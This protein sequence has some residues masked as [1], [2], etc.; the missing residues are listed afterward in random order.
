MVAPKVEEQAVSI[1]NV[2]VSQPRD[3]AVHK[4]RFDSLFNRFS[5]R[6]GKGPLDTVDTGR[7]PA[8]ARQIDSVRASSASQI[9]CPPG[10][11]RVVAFYNIDQLRWADSS[12]P[13]FKAKSVSNLIKD[14]HVGQSEGNS[15]RT[16]NRTGEIAMPADGMPLAASCVSRPLGPLTAGTEVET[17]DIDVM[18]RSSTAIPICPSSPVRPPNALEKCR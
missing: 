16:S 4:P 9:Q 6:D 14:V 13:W 12:V 2:Q 10:R 15:R 17:A 7:N 8:V 5:P 3:I 11:K 18:N 1:A